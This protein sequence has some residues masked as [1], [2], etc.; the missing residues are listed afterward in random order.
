MY[1]SAGTA[2]RFDGTINGSG[3]HTLVALMNYVNPAGGN[4]LALTGGK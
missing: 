4:A 2:L 3:S 1:V